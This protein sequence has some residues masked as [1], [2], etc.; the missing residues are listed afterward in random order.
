MAE[1]GDVYQIDLMERWGSGSGEELHNIFYYQAQGVE[2]VADVL[3][4]EFFE[5]VLPSILAI[6]SPQV[7]VAKITVLSLGNPEWFDENVPAGVHGTA[8]AGNSL[9]PFAAINYTLRLNTRAVRPG[10]KR[11]AGVPEYAQVDGVITDVGYLGNMETLRIDLAAKRGTGIG[12]ENVFWPCVVKRVPYETPG[13][14]SA[15]R[16]PET[17]EETVLGFVTAALTSPVV[18]HQVSRG[19]SR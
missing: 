14:N 18:S 7:V 9:P 12:F 11:F 1:L 16:L 17:N 10:S 6:Q 5:N 3:N 2:D 8:A 13:G 15:Y 19:N 4:V